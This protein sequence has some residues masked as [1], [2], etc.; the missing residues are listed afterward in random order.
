[1]PRRW[2]LLCG[3]LYV[4]IVVATNQ[5]LKTAKI[6]NDNS[7]SNHFLEKGVL[8]ML[9]LLPFI[10]PNFMHC[11]N[12]FLLL[13]S[14]DSFLLFKVCFNWVGSEKVWYVK[15]PSLLND[16]E[17]RAKIFAGNDDISRW[18]TSSRESRK[19]I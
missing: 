18:M 16:R 17:R 19:T 14:D 7:N 10:V 1:M 6:S 4:W 2:R 5:N 13:E 12:T 15:E 8:C 11:L 9:L 3:I